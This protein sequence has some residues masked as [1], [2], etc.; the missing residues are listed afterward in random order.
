MQ[1][2]DVYRVGMPRSDLQVTVRGVPVKPALALGSYA[3][4][5]EAGDATMV[6]GDLVLLDGEVSPVMAQLREGGITVT[7]LHNHLNEMSP[8]VMYLHYEGHGDAVKLA[9]ALHTALAASKTPLAGG[10][11]STPNAVQGLDTQQIE[12]V[13]GHKGRALAEDVFQVS[14]P[15][16]ET[17]KESGIELPPAM[18]VAM[19]LNF[20]ATGNGKAVATGDFV[21]IQQEVEP[22]IDALTQNGIQVEALHN[23]VL[24]DEPRLFYLHF[25]GNDDAVKIAQA[26]RAALADL[27]LLRDAAIARAAR[28]IHERPEHPWTLAELADL[29]AMSR[30]AFASRFRAL[31]GDSPIRYAT[32][33]RLARAARRLRSSD[34]TLAEIAALAGYESE[35]SFSRAFKR[36]FG[37]APGTYRRAAD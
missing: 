16:A 23:H 33:W 24:G 27:E 9:A 8:H 2:G 36:A 10:Q 30:S 22:V 19:P 26:L 3:A 7:A 17:I 28:A 5:H 32:R 13:L 20:Q 15:R 31:T 34:A 29:A 11:A 6:M 21:L 14:I 35:F 12:S 4:F 18:G 1:E 37:V 25:W